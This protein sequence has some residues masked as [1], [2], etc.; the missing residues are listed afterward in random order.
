MSEPE[1][2]SYKEVVEDFKRRVETAIWALQ[3]TYNYI[4][5]SGTLCEKVPCKDCPARETCNEHL[6]RAVNHIRDAI[7]E[8]ASL[9]RVLSPIITELTGE[10]WIVEQEM[11]C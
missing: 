6:D 3:R 8:L 2:V 9:K 1:R 5:I 7:V 4:T 11:R 10:E